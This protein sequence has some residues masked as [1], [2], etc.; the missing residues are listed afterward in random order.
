M[1]LYVHVCIGFENYFYMYM[2]YHSI[3]TPQS[4][5][6]P[7]KQSVSFL[8]SPLLFHFPGCSLWPSRLTNN[9]FLLTLT[10][11]LSMSP[12]SSLSSQGGRHWCRYG[13]WVRCHDNSSAYILSCMYFS[14]VQ[15]PNNHSLKLMTVLYSTLYCRTFSHK[16]FVQQSSFDLAILFWH[17]SWIIHNTREVA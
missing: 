13:R 15:F 11:T 17:T 4:L 10:W 6:V 14:L 12:P 2:W 1:V 3:C 7:C 9:N 16:R 5:S 8:F